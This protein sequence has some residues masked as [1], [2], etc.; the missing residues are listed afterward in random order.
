[1][2]FPLCFILMP[3]GIKKDESGRFINFDSV[4]SNLIVPSVRA[5]KLEPIRADE[6]IQ[7]G[8]IHKPMFER[9]ILCEFAV[10]DLT[11]ANANVYY[12][13]GVR[14]ATRPWST[15]AIFAAETRLPFD[16][17]PFRAIPYHLESDRAVKEYRTDPKIIDPAFIRREN[18]V[19]R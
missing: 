13:L 2:K 6:E 19:C 11:T 7:G 9:L 16:V 4:Y 15:I 5:A 12:E 18:T 1:M 3:F 10:S 14:H 17:A 8:L